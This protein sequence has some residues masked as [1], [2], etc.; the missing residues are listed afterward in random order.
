MPYS[1]TGYQNCTIPS[2]AVDENYSR[3]FYSGHG[4][5]FRSIWQISYYR[6]KMKYLHFAQPEL[7]A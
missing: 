3:L 6:A 2:R 1:G 4:D 7:G 5:Y